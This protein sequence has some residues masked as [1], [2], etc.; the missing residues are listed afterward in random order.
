MT[1][2]RDY[3]FV[4][5]EAWSSLTAGNRPAGTRLA[6]EAEDPDRGA[7]LEPPAGHAVTT[8]RRARGPAVSGMERESG[9]DQWTARLFEPLTRTVTVP[10]LVFP[11]ESFASTVIV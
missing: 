3:S 9:R 2:G 8:K 6:V 10:R 5:W 11:L 7:R 4:G 1:K